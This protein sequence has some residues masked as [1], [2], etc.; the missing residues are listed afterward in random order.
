MRIGDA[1]LSQTRSRPT[2]QPK[3]TVF[4]SVFKQRRA[5]GTRGRKHYRVQA[6]GKHIFLRPLK[7]FERA[8][9]SFKKKRKPE[10]SSK[11]GG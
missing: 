7:L 1:P 9:K 8:K 3:R 2:S 11:G 5:S 6:S 10:K 4:A